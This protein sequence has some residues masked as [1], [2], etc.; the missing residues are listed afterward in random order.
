MIRPS[1][2]T[3]KTKGLA[4]TLIYSCCANDDTSLSSALQD[5]W[6]H[7]GEDEEGD[8]IMYDFDCDDMTKK[9]SHVIDHYKGYDHHPDMDIHNYKVKSI[10]MEVKK[11]NKVNYHIGVKK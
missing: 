2:F 1:F 11:D 8:I 4:G 9:T 5:I 7:I 6:S 10:V 3:N